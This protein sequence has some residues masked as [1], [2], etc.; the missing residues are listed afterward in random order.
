MPFRHNTKRYRQRDRQTTDRRHSVS[1]A[2]PIVRSAKNC[3]NLK[4]ENFWTFQILDFRRKQLK[5]ST[6][7]LVH[8]HI[9]RVSQKKSIPLETFACV[10]VY[11][12]PLEMKIYSVICRSYPHLIANFGPLISIFVRTAALFVTLTPEF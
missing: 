1:K 7:N 11:G 9:Y 12:L 3:E 6:L 8:I 10:S 2:R 4:K 5:L